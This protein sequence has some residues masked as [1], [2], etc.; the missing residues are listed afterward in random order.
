MI[1]EQE[2]E[3]RIKEMERNWQDEHITGQS[4]IDFKDC[5]QFDTLLKKRL[6]EKG[7]KAKLTY[8]FMGLQVDYIRD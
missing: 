4:Y 7:I 8:S 5:S 3:E 6:E 2:I 1:T